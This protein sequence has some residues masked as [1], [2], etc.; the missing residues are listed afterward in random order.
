MCDSTLDESK[1]VLLSLNSKSL[2]FCFTIISLTLSFSSSDK[3]SVSVLGYVK[4]PFS[5][6]FCTNDKVLLIEN[7]LVVNKCVC[8]VDKENNFLGFFSISLLSTFITFIF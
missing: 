7:L 6:K 1:I 3:Y 2:L 4:N 8:N 5:Y